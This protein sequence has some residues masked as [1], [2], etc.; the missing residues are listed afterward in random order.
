MGDTDNSAY[1]V[2]FYFKMEFSIGP[3]RPELAF[4][5]V[6]GLMVELDMEK[7]NGGGENGF[8]FRLPKRIKHT[9]LV[10]KRALVPL[11]QG[12]LSDWIKSFFD[13]R[14]RIKPCS[15]LVSLVDAQGNKLAAWNVT[16]AYPVKWEISHLDA[17][18]D[19]PVIE[20]LEMAYNDIIR[21][22]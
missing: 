19:E 14:E 8:G 9:N 16:D 12:V 3:D 1:P 5:E 20:T 7:I 2:S 21:K 10:C 13:Y 15:I 6:S 11:E 18:K 17:R 22:R 4:R